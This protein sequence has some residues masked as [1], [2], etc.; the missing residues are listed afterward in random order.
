MSSTTFFSLATLVF[1][2]AL[3]KAAP[4]IQTVQNNYAFQGR[5]CPIAIF[6]TEALVNQKGGVQGTYDFTMGLMRASYNLSASFDASIGLPVSKY[7]FA[8]DNTMADCRKKSGDLCDAAFGT[9]HA[10]AAAQL[11]AFKAIMK[12]ENGYFEGIAES[13]CAN[14]LLG[15]GTWTD[16]NGALTMGLSLTGTACNDDA[17][18]IGYVHTN[19]AGKTLDAKEQTVVM[20][21]EIM[22]ILGASHDERYNQPQCLGNY[23]MATVTEEDS[24]NLDKESQCTKSAVAQYL[25]KNGSCLVQRNAIR[26][27]QFPKAQ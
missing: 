22:H 9:A 10:N 7:W 2:V 27:K 12:Q 19:L 26:A 25:T 6:A 15:A 1:F 18:N 3:T 11:D 5:D 24:P 17:T 14:M 23:M 13:S 21:H 4:L 16:P 8:T 20:T